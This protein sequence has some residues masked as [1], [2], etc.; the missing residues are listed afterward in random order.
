PGK[1]CS[2]A[3]KVSALRGRPARRF[4][5]LQSGREWASSCLQQ[6]V[7][8]PDSEKPAKSV[9]HVRLASACPLGQTAQARRTKG[10]TI[11]FTALYFYTEGEYLAKH[12]KR[13]NIPA[14][15][16]PAARHVRA[17]RKSGRIAPPPLDPAP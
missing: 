16:D 5:N 14:R 12:G 4:C 10:L 9:F 7:T 3:R 8:I 11:L 1:G 13:E 17:H 2:A 15:S 6:K